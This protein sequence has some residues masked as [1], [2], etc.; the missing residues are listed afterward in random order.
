VCCNVLDYCAPVTNEDKYAQWRMPVRLAPTHGPHAR[1]PAG[2]PIPILKRACMEAEQSSQCTCAEPR[3]HT[4]L[5][6]VGSLQR[7]RRRARRPGQAASSVGTDPTEVVAQAVGY[8]SRRQGYGSQAGAC[9]RG[10]TAASR[11]PPGSA[12]VT[13]EHSRHLRRGGEFAQ[14]CH[15]RTR[16]RSIKRDSTVCWGNP[17]P[18]AAIVSK[19]PARGSTL[20]DAAP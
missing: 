11:G 6:Q 8:G 20:A 15:K 9:G 1:G 2:V 3:R 19:D 14:A 18:Y 10:R 12:V 17:I 4:V 13:N 7:G 5:R 16:H